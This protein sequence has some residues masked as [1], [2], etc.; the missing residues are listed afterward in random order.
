[1]QAGNIIDWLRDCYQQDR[2]QMGVRDFFGS[3]VKCRRMTVGKERLVNDALPN[4]V[5]R[6][7][8]QQKI[9]PMLELYR[10]ERQGVYGAL[11]LVG[12]VQR[13][14]IGK[15]TSSLLR[16]PL[17]L[18]PIELDPLHANVFSVHLA[19]WWLNSECLKWLGIHG[20]KQ[21]ELEEIIA[22]GVLD[23]LKVSTICEFLQNES[24]H[25]DSTALEQW[26]ALMTTKEL[27]SLSES[28]DLSIVPAA[29][30]GVMDRPRHSRGVL[31]ELARLAPISDQGFSACLQA[32][33]G[34][35]AQE[36]SSRRRE[37]K[38]GSYVDSVPATLSQA[39]ESLVHSAREHVLTLCHG[40]PGTGKSFTLSA[41]ALE[42]RM[43]G[44][45]VLVVSRGEHAVEALFDVME[46]MLGSKDGLVRTGRKQY[47]AEWKEF[48]AACLRGQK[49]AEAP[50]REEL[51]EAERALKELCGSIQKQENYLEKELSKS[52]PR[53]QVMMDDSASLV[54][55]MKR[56][57]SRREVGKRPL[58]LQLTLRIEELHRQRENEIRRVQR[59]RWLRRLQNC[60]ERPESRKQLTVML[61]S[62]RKRRG[63]EQ[64]KV[65]A[66]A[67][68]GQL[69]EIFPVWIVEAEDLHRVLTLQKSLFDVVLIDEASQCD[70]TTCIPAMQRARRAVI[71]GDQKQ[72]RHVSFLSNDKLIHSAR[73]RQIES[74]LSDVFHY[75]DKNL[76]DLAVERVTSQQQVGF[77]NKYFRGL[78][79]LIRFSNSRFYQGGLKVMRD[80]PWEVAP[81][82]LEE[83]YCAGVRDARGVNEVEVE[84]IFEHL[85]TIVERSER[86]GVYPSLGVLSPFRK[87]VDALWQEFQKDA[88]RELLAALR[89]RHRFALGTSH[90]FQG[91][92]RDMM[93]VSC[94]VDAQTHAG[95]IRFMERVDVFNV[96][97]T[98]ARHKQWIYTSVRPSELPENSL[99]ADYLLHLKEPKPRR[100]D[101]VARGDGFSREVLDVLGQNG[102]MVR[103]G[104]DVVGYGIDIL[105][106]TA[107]GR[108]VGIDLVGYQGVTA[109]RLAQSACRI[110]G[111]AGFLVLPLGFAEW[112]ENQQ[113]CVKTLREV[114]AEID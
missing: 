49:T 12:K 77:L 102:V 51:A 74:V 24:V 97:V 45:S 105:V 2:P 68:M 113:R 108:W 43:R 96:A 5:L 30:M 35:V 10:R 73:E 66:Q 99:L 62:L 53:G 61:D 34:P 89:N 90:S 109:P 47:L 87:Q 67:D 64:E 28:S 4:D 39:Q 104:D 59:M 36:M 11:F 6:A 19:R 42:H 85:G 27:E 31:D 106:K 98:R 75:R 54:R 86:T 60:L 37:L 57:L 3:G 8:D 23:G 7:S 76:L 71:A 26:P 58:L 55:S 29:G 13:E 48:L 15:R 83:V 100:E 50:S 107:K 40:P 92:E 82:A 72:L 101:V 52:L 33:Y 112:R 41:I 79:P 81:K 32:L 63:T 80:R 65:F 46:S 70:L 69:L 114:L 22:D 91:L 1:M 38:E 17:I 21:D 9:V 56:W 111:R 93:L 103:G 16:A 95:A 20:E 14:V 78:E 84:A 110:M 18:Y 25:V 88:G 44:D 94:V